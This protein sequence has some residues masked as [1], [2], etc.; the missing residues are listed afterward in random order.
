MKLNFCARRPNAMKSRI[1]LPKS[2]LILLLSLFAG[3][4]SF[5]QTASA[6]VTSELEAPNHEATIA[7][8]F[9]GRP[10]AM[11]HWEGQYF[12]SALA[13][14]TRPQ[15]NVAL[16]DA[17]GY[18]V[19]EA[20]IWF[21]DSVSVKIFDAAVTP[22][23]N[24]VASGYAGKSDGSMAFFIAKIDISGAVTHVVRTNPFKASKVCALDEDSVWSFGEELDKADAG[25]DYKMLRN[26]SFTQGLLRSYVS[27][28]S[29][30][31]P[32]GGV[33][34]GVSPY[35]LRCSGA[36]V[37]AYVGGGREYLQLNVAN[38]TLDR[39]PVKQ[40]PGDMVVTGFALTGTGHVYA[41]LN[42]TGDGT[43]GL[44]GLFELKYDAP[45]K[46]VQWVPVQSTV[47]NFQSWQKVQQGA[48]LDLVG[49]DGT[50]LIYSRFHQTKTLLWAKPIIKKAVATTNVK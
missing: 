48:F 16:Y 17:T 27:S 9:V 41:S 11:P 31:V 44:R 14:V 3:M 2:V 10:A 38:N 34:V 7:D 42:V 24:V 37:V 18:R 49:T 5:A 19:R 30:K 4:Q 23:G 1:Y 45:A 28:R 40:M 21:P 6:A 35:W 46:Q 33:V 32:A 12:V 15:P 36:K 20:T 50:N 13:E 26:Y 25:L 47:T 22:L 39:F 43:L 8:S 29:I